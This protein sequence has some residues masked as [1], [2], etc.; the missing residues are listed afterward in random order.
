MSRAD[1][2]EEAAS[3]PRTSSERSC[4]TN[5]GSSG[6]SKA[7][8][9][10]SARRASTSFLPAEGVSNAGQSC[11]ASSGET[12][13]SHVKACRVNALAGL[14]PSKS[15]TRRTQPT[16]GGV[17]RSARL[18]SKLRPPWSRATT[19]AHSSASVAKCRSRCS[20]GELSHASARWA[21]SHGWNA[22]EDS[23]PPSLM[24]ISSMNWLFAPMST[25]LTIIPLTSSPT[26]YFFQS[27]VGTLSFP[28]FTHPKLKKTP[29]MAEELVTT[30]STLEPTVTSS[31]GIPPLCLQPSSGRFCRH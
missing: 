8:A 23:T 27:A 22:P 4:A 9:S 15:N 5:W 21:T 24:R 17:P 31:T 3:T 10:Q 14:C 28:S 26:W 12:C 16:G 11:T 1:G 20:G 7:L 30:P 25:L 19:E 2:M 29:C 13:P 6:G 18:A